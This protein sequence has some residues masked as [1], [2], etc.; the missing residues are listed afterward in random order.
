MPIYNILPTKNMGQNLSILAYSSQK[1]LVLG[2]VVE[3]TIR[4]SVDFGLVLGENMEIDT[5]LE[6]KKEDEEKVEEINQP[7]KKFAIR[8]IN[9]IL[10][11]QISKQQLDWL[12]I[13]ADNSFNS[14]NDIWDA[15]WRPLELLTK[16][17]WQELEEISKEIPTNFESQTN[18]L[19]KPQVEPKVEFLLDLE[20]TLRIISIIRNITPIFNNDQKP[21]LQGK[22]KQVLIV[23]PEKKYL[24]KI[25]KEL[26]K[27]LKEVEA[28]YKK[29]DIKTNLKKEI[30]IKYEL[31][32]FTADATKKSKETIWKMLQTSL[33]NSQNQIQQNSPTLQ[34]ICT[35][36]SGLFLPFGKF[37]ALEQVILVDEGNSL[38][39]QD[40]N[41]LYY[42]T[43]EAIF[44]ISKAFL[45]NIAF[46][47]PLPSVRL[48][49]F[50]DKELLE[51][52][53]T[54]TS[55]TIQK[56]RKIK[57]TRFDRK[58]AKYDI[59]GWEIEQILKPDEDL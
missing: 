45:S 52:Q 21:E 39:I 20:I 5:K 59:F 7:T 25:Y 16:K 44:L 8:E 22:N 41:G 3:I 55:Q 53:M 38:Y 56:P 51:T 9:S 27:N 19:S 54:K 11:I 50:Y 35:T 40:Q 23:F 12:K 43:R 6:T 10:P 1:I 15:I 42:D 47:S 58:S 36:R 2:Q 13:F 49:S 37:G 32:Y 24:D 17:Q 30:Q 46:I 26:N 31:Q 29:L 18:T 33:H 4:N 48:H 14:L 34:I 57:I 28:S